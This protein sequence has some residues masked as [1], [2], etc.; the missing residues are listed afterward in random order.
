MMSIDLN[1]LLGSPSQKKE[2]KRKEKKNQGE[3]GEKR[4]KKKSKEKERKKEAELADGLK[5]DSIA[6]VLIS[7]KFASETRRGVDGPSIALD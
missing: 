7:R 4:F 2:R 1:L 6:V 5:W 3:K